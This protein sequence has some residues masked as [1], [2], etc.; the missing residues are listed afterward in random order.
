MSKSSHDYRFDKS[1]VFLILILL[2]V[3]V[4]AVFIMIN[5]RID[6]VSEALGQ[7]SVYKVL[8][9]LEDNGVPISI[10]VM[11]YYPETHRAAMFDIPGDIGKIIKSLD[12]E[13]GRASCRERV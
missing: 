9:V 7:D 6:P 12:R 3:V 13:I 11:A 10:S 1:I 8:F 4:S 2:I 5:I